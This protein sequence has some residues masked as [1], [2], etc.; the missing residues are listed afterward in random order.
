ML[1]KEGDIN[2]NTTI[3]AVYPELLGVMNSEYENIQL[4]QLL[5]HLRNETE[6]PNNK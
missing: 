3:V 4:D 6:L 1:V 2:S 5:S